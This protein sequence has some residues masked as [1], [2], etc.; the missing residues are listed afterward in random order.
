MLLLYVYSWKE[1]IGGEHYI[2][3]SWKGYDFNTLDSL[4]RKGYVSS[5]HRAK[6]VVI[7]E[8]GLERAKKLKET[9]LKEIGKSY[10]PV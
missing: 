5:S 8:E 4:A 1:K 10:G 6:S 7:T 2:T 3:K 9:L